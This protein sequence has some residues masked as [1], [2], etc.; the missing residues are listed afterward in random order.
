MG[1]RCFWTQEAGLSVF[2]GNP[3]NAVFRQDV[4]ET[5]NAA[6][7]TAT[8]ASGTIRV[9][10][11][12]IDND[13]E[14][15]PLLVFREITYFPLTWAF[16][17]DEFGWKYSYTHETGLVISSADSSV[18]YGGYEWAIAENGNGFG[19]MRG[20]E[21]VYVTESG[22]HSP[23]LEKRGENLYFVYWIG[24]IP[25]TSQ[26]HIVQITPHGMIREICSGR[27]AFY[28]FGDV[29]VR[30][31]MDHT[32]EVLGADDVWRN[33][34]RDGFGYSGYYFATSDPA[35]Y[36]DGFIYTT[37]WVAGKEEYVRLKVDVQT[38]E[39]TKE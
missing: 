7:Y 3:D 35:V 33:I 15:Y 38:G 22:A 5:P 13:A 25:T 24:N 10:E 12:L 29:I 4:R 30:F 19:L 1:L 6:K 16:C 11:T 37:G 34:G 32:I 18:N 20:G 36:R 31:G 28:D 23:K 2:A 21:S 26:E 39:T 17:V 14:T 9:N 27:Y 8:V